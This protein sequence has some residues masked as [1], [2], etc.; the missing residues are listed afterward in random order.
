[1]E[2]LNLL[3]QHYCTGSSL[4]CK[5][6]ASIS[7]L[8]L[9]LG[10]NVCPFDLPYGDWHYMAPLSWVKMLWRTLQ[11]TGFELHLEHE[12]IPCPR[13]GDLL[14][15]DR[16]R[17]MAGNNVDHLAKL[18]RVRGSLGAIFISDIVTADGKYIEQFAVEKELSSRLRR[19][20][21]DFPKEMP[22]DR[23]WELWVSYLRSMTGENFELTTPL[24]AWDNVSHRSWEW[25]LSDGGGV[26]FQKAANG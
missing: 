19:S 23:D 18:A 25:V 20:T 15:M 21:Y 8:Q 9:Q 10:V 12:V 22:T 2:R 3:L 24:G 26:L 16:L 4:S 7:F 5:L 6:S 14:I 17:E 13:K 11:V 1:M